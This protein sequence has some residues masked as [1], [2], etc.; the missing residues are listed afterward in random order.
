MIENKKN[1]ESLEKSIYALQ[2]KAK[3]INDKIK[4]PINPNIILKVP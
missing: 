3:N 4:T 2:D 1:L